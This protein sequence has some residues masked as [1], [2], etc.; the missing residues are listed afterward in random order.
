MET[1]LIKIGGSVIPHL[2]KSFF[3]DIKNLLTSGFYPVIVHGGGPSI[4]KLLGELN[5]E[6]TFVDGLRVTN[7][8]TLKIVQM[9]LA[10]QEGKDLVKNF[11]LAG[12]KALNLSGIDLNLLEAEALNEELGLVGKV[13]KVNGV[14]FSYLE[15]EKII[16]IITPLGMGKDGEI[17]N[18]NADTAAQA[19]AHYLNV[20]KLIFVSDIEGIYGLKEGRNELLPYINKEE[21]EEL[22]A[23]KIITKGMIPKVK[24]AVNALV[25]GL[26]QAWIVD[27]KK[28]GVIKEVIFHNQGGT[29]LT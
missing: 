19:I 7:E 22:I 1:I 5:I 9:V 6:S 16:P 8:K 4:T 15:Q 23:A 14:I 24:E 21:V 26:K 20:K 29:M 3:Q 25:N 28:E 13:T 2:P 17:Y 11:E 18:I 12:A 10:G 27:G